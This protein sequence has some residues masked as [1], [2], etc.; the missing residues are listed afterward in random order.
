MVSH[1]IG[2]RLPVDIVALCELLDNLCGSLIVASRIDR[3]HTLHDI[4]MPRSWLLRVLPTHHTLAGKGTTLFECYVKP[5]A[6]LLE[7]I[8]TCDAGQS[9]D[10][11]W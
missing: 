10:R 3:A 9:T 4:T 2:N 6:A 8:Y 1:I 11:G 7:Q 5:V